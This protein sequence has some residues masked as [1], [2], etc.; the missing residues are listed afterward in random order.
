MDKKKFLEIYK[1]FDKITPI[2]RN[3]GKI[4][5]SKCCSGK[6]TDGMLLF[7]GEES[8]FENEDGFNVY[9]DKK[10]GYYCVSCNGS[11]KRELRP[12]SCRIFPYFIYI[13]EK[14]GTPTVA[15]DMRAVD[16]CPLLTKNYKIN[17]D[18]MRQLRILS[19]KLSRETDI[20]D[21]LCTITEKL[22]DFNGL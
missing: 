21:F 4:C 3:C 22:T 20:K 19:K 8:I 15:P 18:F 12:L 13:K 16:F 9:F 2:R 14:D 17:S 11:C 5:S 10:Y 6:S 1:D 7:P